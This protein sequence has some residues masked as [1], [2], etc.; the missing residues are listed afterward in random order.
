MNTRFGFS[1]S[2]TIL[3]TAFFIWFCNNVSANNLCLVFVWYYV[4]HACALHHC[5]HLSLQYS[6]LF[7][8]SMQIPRWRLKVVLLLF[9]RMD[10]DNYQVPLGAAAKGGGVLPAVT[11]PGLRRASSCSS[12]RGGDCHETVGVQREAGHV[13]VPGESIGAG[14]IRPYKHPRRYVS[15]HFHHSVHFTLNNHSETELTD[16]YMPVQW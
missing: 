12:S 14:F 5:L 11:Q 3:F 4:N 13:H 9:D 16:F 1:S 7:I 2:N 15:F 8:C 10:S 6:T